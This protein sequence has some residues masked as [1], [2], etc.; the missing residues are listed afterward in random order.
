MIT[1]GLISLW[2]KPR[3]T[4]TQAVSAPMPTTVP[5]YPAIC[6]AGTERNSNE[7]LPLDK[8]STIKLFVVLC[9]VLREPEELFCSA[10]PPTRVE[11]AAV[12]CS[13]G[14]PTLSLLKQKMQIRVKFLEFWTANLIS[15]VV[16]L[17]QF[18]S[19]S[20]QLEKKKKQTHKQ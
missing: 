12:F 14:S 19:K 13:S 9:Q 11:A 5:S 17:Q 20:T 7:S 8:C 2:A 6:Q 1:R 18:L 4:F 16:L 15:I 10:K 3:I